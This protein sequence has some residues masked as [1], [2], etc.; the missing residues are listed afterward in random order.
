MI[1]WDSLIYWYTN[2]SKKIQTWLSSDQE[3][4]ADYLFDYRKHHIYHTELYRG[5]KL[6]L[7]PFLRKH[8]IVKNCRRQ[9]KTWKGKK[10]GRGRYHFRPKADSTCLNNI[11]VALIFP[12]LF[13]KTHPPNQ[14][15]NFSLCQ[16][17]TTGIPCAHHLW[18]THKLS[19]W[20][21][22]VFLWTSAQ[23]NAR[24]GFSGSDNVSNCSNARPQAKLQFST[25]DDTQFW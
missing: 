9:E 6:W 25:F 24:T 23:V 3:K 18:T 14:M 22:L 13:S 5:K 17:I 7:H 15:K 4:I 11:Q 16:L 10:R 20:T 1:I 8:K 2:K 19:G 12:M 21:I